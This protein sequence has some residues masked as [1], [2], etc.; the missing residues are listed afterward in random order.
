MP[1]VTVAGANGSTVTIPYDSQLNATLAGQLAAAITAGVNDGS[2]TPYESFGNP[3]PLLPPGQTGEFIL[4]N[5]GIAALSPE[6]KAV[7]VTASSA[8]VFG[9]GA[10]GESV[11]SGMG[12]LTF[13]SDGGAGT[14]VAGGGNNLIATT[15]GLGTSGGDWL[16]NTGDGNDT[17]LATTG[18]DT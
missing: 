12:N 14:V 6:Y 16:I 18:S 13:F 2:I 9:G 10:A 5:P 1:S 7:V 11:L 17:I 8:T 3:P 4:Q 15:P